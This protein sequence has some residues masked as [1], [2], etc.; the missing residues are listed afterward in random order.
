MKEYGNMS[1]LKVPNSSITESKENEII[2]M[3][4]KDFRSLVLKIINDLK[5]DSYR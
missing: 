4:E 1:P 3:P 2:N 5:K